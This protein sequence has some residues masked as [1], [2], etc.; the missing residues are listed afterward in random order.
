M[1]TTK[2][3]VSKQIRIATTAFANAGGD[4]GVGALLAT[5]GYDAPRLEECRA[6]LDAA[7]AAVARQVAAQGEF[8]AACARARD[9]RRASGR[10]YQAVSQIARAALAGDG[11]ALTTLGLDRPMPRRTSLF[12]T[13]A[14]ALLDNAAA[15]P[16]IATRLARFGYTSERLAAER[17]TVLALVEAVRAQE[18]A[19]GAAQQATVEQAAAMTRL[20]AE[21]STFRRVAK[22]ALR[23]TP[24][25]LETL[26]FMQRSEPTDAQRAAVQ[27]A[28]A[29]RKANRQRAEDENQVQV[30]QEVGAS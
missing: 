14:T 15:T 19:K 5:F 10:A 27:K 23:D 7:T 26:G 6:A 25:L 28:A 1:P 18:A 29:T 22:V 3:K 24:Q 17:A 12:V 8:Q 9:A 20:N 30:E 4:A 11:A 16:S 21:L 13:M 2:G